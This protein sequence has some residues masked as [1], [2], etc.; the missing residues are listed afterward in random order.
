MLTV[1]L[2]HTHATQRDMGHKAK[3]KHWNFFTAELALKNLV[4]MSRQVAPLMQ[5]DVFVETWDSPLVRRVFSTLENEVTNSSACDTQHE[6]AAI[7]GSAEA[8]AAGAASCALVKP[9]RTRVE[10][11]NESY[12]ISVAQKYPWANLLGGFLKIEDVKETPHVVD[13][14][15]KRY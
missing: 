9:C 10:A 6:S 1:S 4:N 11:Y 13:F 12:A 3:F 7:E 15:Y 14:F 8:R 2:P 5:V